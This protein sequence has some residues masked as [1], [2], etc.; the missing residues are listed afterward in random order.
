[1]VPEPVRG[2]FFQWQCLWSFHCAE[3]CPWTLLSAAVPVVLPWCRSLPVDSSFSGS[4][5]GS[6]HGVG[7]CTWTL[8][9]VA[10]PVVLSM[11]PKPARGLFFQ[12]QCLWFCPWCRSLYVDPSFSG[13]ACGSVHGVGACTWTLLSVAVPV[14]L[15]MVPKPARGL[16][17][18]WQCLWFCPWC[19]SLYVDPSF[20]GSACG[21]V[22]GAKA[23]PWTLLSVLVPMVMSMVLKSVRGQVFQ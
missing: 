22:H 11:V 23:C 14:V 21:S 10:V 16:F 19:R 13:S 12:W 15:S 20:S 3:A 7:A 4:A 17:F 2:P 18:Q 6:V 8:L 1:M 5:C 9:S